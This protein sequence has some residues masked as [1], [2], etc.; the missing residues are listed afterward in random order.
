MKKNVTNRPVKKR[1]TLPK[2]TNKCEICY[3][4]MQKT[5]K[6]VTN[7]LA[8]TKKNVTI[9]YIMFILWRERNVTKK[10]IS[11]TVEVEK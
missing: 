4:N 7:C 11:G 1:K 8:K 2:Y 9:I 5:K 3:I 10:S 6:N